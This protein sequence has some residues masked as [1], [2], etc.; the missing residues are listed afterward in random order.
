MEYSIERQITIA[1][2]NQPGRLAAIGQALA[3]QRVNI[4]AISVLDTIEQGVIRLVTSDPALCKQVL[5]E[6]GF[7]V[8]EA[9]V[10]AVHINDS[11]GKLALLGGALADAGI[12]IAYAYGS[13]PKAGQFTR[14]MFK[15]SNTARACEVLTA[16]DEA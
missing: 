2:E 13:V 3:N 12:N 7:Y 14:V 15:V 4:E 1:L 10:L 16:L 6:Q 5:T 9:E 8:I 11:P